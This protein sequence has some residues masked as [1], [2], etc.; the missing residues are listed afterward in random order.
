VVSCLYRG[1]KRTVLCGFDPQPKTTVYSPNFLALI[2]RFF[3]TPV[4]LRR[5]TGSICCRFL[6]Q[7]IV[8]YNE[9]NYSKQEALKNV[10]P[11]RD[12]EPPHAHSPGVATGTI[13]RRLRIDPRR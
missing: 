7:P 9:I 4:L 12:C 1:E 3:S 10:G 11:I 8:G 5:H 2:I 13:A 6:A